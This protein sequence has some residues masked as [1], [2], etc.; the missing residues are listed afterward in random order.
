MKQKELKFN[1]LIDELKQRNLF[2][3][4]TNQTKLK[5]ALENNYGIYIGFDPTAPSLHLGNYVG[6]CV[7]K[8]FKKFGFKT[9]AV[10]GGATGLIGDP[11]FKNYER[12]LLDNQIAINNGLKI[13]DQLYKYSNCDLVVDNYDFYQKMNVVDFLRNVGKLINVNY[14]LEKEALKERLRTGL[15]FTEFTYPILQGWDF[16]CLYKNYNIAIQAGGS[17]Q[18]GNITTGIEMIRKISNEDLNV[19]GLT[20]NLLTDNQ[21]NKFGKSEGNALF[22]DSNLTNSYLIYQFLLNTDDKDVEKFLKA[23]TFLTI[24][25]INLVCQKH[26]K[27]PQFRLGQKKLANQIIY[28]LYGDNELIKCQTLAK[29]LFENQ[30]KNLSNNDYKI[31]A[32]NIPFLKVNKSQKL[33]QLLVDV[34][35]ENSLGNARKLIMNNGLQIN[36]KKISDLNYIVNP[37]I[38]L[39]YLLVKKGKKKYALFLV[40]Q[41]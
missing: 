25:E 29:I 4:C 10:I 3:D 23:L 20:F 5:L 8:H 2:Y 26:F 40:C 13:K 34:G 37:S 21:N 9:I 6:L 22:L 18:W 31:L 32:D 33:I 19:A 39:Q 30:D 12:K 28:D 27:N 14:L 16:W 11:S 7:L 15:S 1:Q 24:D 41:N 38:D 17:D 35:L 36:S